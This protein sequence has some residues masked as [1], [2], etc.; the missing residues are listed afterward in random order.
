MGE[1]AED[2]EE[3]GGKTV[4]EGEAAAE[5]APSH[6][7]EEIEREV[8]ELRAQLQQQEAAAREYLD[9]AKR[10]QADFDN[11]RKRA[12]REKQETI[13]R[14]NDK[15]ILEL[16]PALDDLERARDATGGADDL[17]VAIMQIIVNLTS[18]LRS[19]GLRE[20]PTDVPFD[21]NLHEG[22]CAEKGEEGK[23]LEVFQKGYF[24]GSNVLRHAKVKVG[25]Q[26]T[27]E[28]VTEGESHG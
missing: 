24:L 19:Y 9:L 23:I 28:E 12:L 20:I 3:Q 6:D 17:R 14:A 13:A 10:I 26:E 18:L 25:K 8:D 27:V 5:R 21:P 4:A 1:K 2:G 22:L 7:M 15:L 11:Y 16:L